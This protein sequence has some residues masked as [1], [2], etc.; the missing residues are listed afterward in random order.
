MPCTRWHDIYST[1]EALIAQLI[2]SIALFHIP[3]TWIA[4]RTFL[5]HFLI[6]IYGYAHISHPSLVPCSKWQ[7]ENATLR[8]MHDYRGVH[9]KI[10][11]ITSFLIPNLT[12]ITSV[13]FF[14]LLICNLIF[15]N[16]LST[17]HSRHVVDETTKISLSAF[18]DFRRVDN[19]YTQ[20]HYFYLVPCHEEYLWLI[21]VFLFLFLFSL[22]VG[23]TLWSS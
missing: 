16:M 6:V 17:H 18:M 12:C 14:F 4:S 13:T 10:Y 9:N 3:S 15:K 19:K 1:F 20:Q 7:N 8:K 11:W 21:C 5:L 23:I 2:Q 22:V